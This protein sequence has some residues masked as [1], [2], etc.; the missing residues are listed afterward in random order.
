MKLLT[1]AILNKLP[2][3][4]ETESTPV[5]DKMIHLKL[6]GGPSYTYY[7]A[8]YD[9]QT[10]EMFGW[11]N[12]EW[13]YSNIHEIAAVRFPPFGLPVERDRYFRSCKFSEISDRQVQATLD[14]PVVRAQI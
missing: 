3:I 14:K 10:G 11:T 4:G 1:K 7:C 8:E 2:G 5:E 13:G 12:G 9:P 6:F